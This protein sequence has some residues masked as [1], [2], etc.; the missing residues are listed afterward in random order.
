[1]THPIEVVGLGR[2][3][4]GEHALT[5]V[6]LHVGAG[7]IHAIVGL[8]GAGKTTLM[9]LLLGMM[10]P[11]T[12]H[13]RILGH[14]TQGAPADLW[15]AVGHQIE[16][17]FAYPELTVRENLWAGALLHGVARVETAGVVSRS[18]ERFGLTP[19]AD[20]RAGTLSLG[21][22]QRLGLATAVAHDPGILVFDEP[23]NALD[24]AGVVFLRSLLEAGREGGASALV[25][26]HHLDEVARVADRITVIHRG[27]II[28]GL[29]PGGID[30]E[31]RFFELVYAHEVTV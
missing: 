10:R 26:S 20:R 24:P 1:M 8:N 27:R 14:D 13:A 2:S 4:D 15:R 18:I 31:R 22:R 30:L 16:T 25:S 3:F 5:G 29:D 23:T 12:G 17:P 11:D 7:E 28:G 21:N 9:R 6:D 19:W